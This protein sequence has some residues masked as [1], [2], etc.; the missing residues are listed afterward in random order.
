MKLNVAESSF[1]PATSRSSCWFSLRKPG[2]RM[3]SSV[4]LVVDDD[5]AL[6]ESI[7]DILEVMAGYQVI[8]A[9]DRSEALVK[10][11]ELRPC[12]IILDAILPGMDAQSFMAE[13]SKR[14]LSDGRTPILLISASTY[15]EH[16]AAEVS[17]PAYLSKPFDMHELLVEVERL[18]TL[19]TPPTPDQ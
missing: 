10:V 18:I 19:H 8:T 12:L 7:R 1:I 2:A 17:A 6:C 15:V 14:G 4:V 5:R 11:G 13:L 3:S 9:A 16:Y